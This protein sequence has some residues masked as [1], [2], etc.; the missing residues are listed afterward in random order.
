MQIFQRF[1]RSSFWMGGFFVAEEN[2]SFRLQ[3]ML[4]YDDKPKTAAS[5]YGWLE[6]KSKEPNA[7][8][9]MHKATSRNTMRAAKRKEFLATRL[10]FWPPVRASGLARKGKGRKERMTCAFVI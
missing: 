10:C 2:R 5:P 6:E 7:V 1:G 4:P 8:T 9:E 3:R